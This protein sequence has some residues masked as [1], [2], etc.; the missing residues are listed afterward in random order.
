[1]TNKRTVESPEYQE[2]YAAAKATD[3]DSAKIQNP[4]IAGTTPWDRWYV[5]WDDY[6]KAEKRK[7]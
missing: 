3:G 7:G 5:G 4:Y 6:T 2:G 1:M